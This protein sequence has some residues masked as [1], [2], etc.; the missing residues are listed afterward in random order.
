MAKAK[1]ESETIPL[2]GVDLRQLLAHEEQ[3]KINE[4]SSEL[5]EV[6]T[7]HDCTLAA[8]VIIS[9]NQVQSFVRIIPTRE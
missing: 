1:D 6:L 2:S 3:R 8:Q 5:N 4:C 7:K 9:G